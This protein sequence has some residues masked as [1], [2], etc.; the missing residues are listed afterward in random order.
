MFSPIVKGNNFEP[1]FL[2]ILRHVGLVPYHISLAPGD[3]E[4]INERP[5][6][7]PVIIIKNYEELTGRYLN[8]GIMLR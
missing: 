2:R 5:G 6:R 1:E 3:G 4:G 8:V 7:I